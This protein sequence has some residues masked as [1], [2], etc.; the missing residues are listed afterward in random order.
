MARKPSVSGFSGRIR[1]IRNGEFIELTDLEQR[2]IEAMDRKPTAGES[3][4]KQDA[5][6]IIPKRGR[7]K[8]VRV[9]REFDYRRKE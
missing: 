9:F 2:I 8:R 4:A 7:A 1:V 5:R 3:I 6:K